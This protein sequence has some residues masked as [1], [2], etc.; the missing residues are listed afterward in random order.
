MLG[1]LIQYPNP[2]MALYAMNESLIALLAKGWI[3]KSL[4]FIVLI[5]GVLEL[6]VK[7]GGVNALV[8]YLSEHSQRITNKRSA[9]LLGYILGIFIFIESTITSLTV[10]AITRPL[11]GKFGASPAK[12]AYICDVTSAPVCSLIPLNGWG[13]LLSVLVSAKITEGVVN[14]NA[15]EIVLESIMFNFYAMAT[16]L[17]G[18]FIVLSGKDFGAMKHSE[19]NYVA[20]QESI[21][22]DNEIPHGRVSYMVYPIL[23][24]ITLVTLFMMIDGKGDITQGSGTTAVYYAV[25]GTLVLSVLYFVWVEKVFSL[26]RF[27]SIVNEGSRSMFSL[28]V[29]ML[30]AFGIAEV[31]KTM[32]T[33]AYLVSFL[34]SYGLTPTFVPLMIFLTACLISFATGTS[35]GTFSIMVPIGIDM[36]TGFSI[37]PMIAVG[38]AVA[39]GVFGDHCSPI[40]DTTIISALASKCDPL[41]HVATQL[42]YALVAAFIAALGYL[43]VGFTL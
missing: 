39:G 42:P 5:G 18:L 16:L 3:V 32:Q 22:C 17:F 10:G 7:S 26:Q 6:M 8:M 40:S 15:T 36:A 21:V 9:L 4:V 14:G 29:I 11:A 38:A 30:L 27:F 19:A 34:T 23:W 41:E 37:S 20:Q 25:W 13:A 24:L 2:F 28:G 35:W 12:V 31:T 33:G 43:I 1:F